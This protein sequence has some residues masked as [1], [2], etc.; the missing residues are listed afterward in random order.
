[1]ARPFLGEWRNA[2]LDSDVDRTAVLVGLV[3]STFANATGTCHPGKRRIAQDSRLSKRAVDGAV[4]RL[5]AAGLVEVS[6]SRGHSQNGYQFILPTVQVA[7]P[8]T[9]SNG[10]ASDT[11]RCRSEHPTVQV[12]APKSAES[13]ERVTAGDSTALTRVEITPACNCGT[14]EENHANWCEAFAA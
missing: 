4:D 6:R 8:L 3:L 7:A 9:A 10:A 12:A 14:R 13:A 2:L 5:E 11:Q 1:M